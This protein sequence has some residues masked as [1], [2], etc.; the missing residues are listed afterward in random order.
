MKWIHWSL[1]RKCLALFFISKENLWNSQLIQKL[2]L[3]SREKQHCL[4]IRVIF[5]LIFQIMGGV[6]WLYWIAPSKYKKVK[7]PCRCIQERKRNNGWQQRQLLVFSCPKITRQS[8]IILVSIVVLWRFM[9]WA[10][11]NNTSST[12]FRGILYAQN[13]TIRLVN[14]WKYIICFHY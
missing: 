8:L 4:G 10:T 1:W 13:R 3:N 5:W 11:N 14:K 9:P 6:Y 2:M 12:R 7:L